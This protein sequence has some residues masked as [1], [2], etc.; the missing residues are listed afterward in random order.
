M[1]VTETHLKTRSIKITLLCPQKRDTT[2]KVCRILSVAAQ[3]YKR[4]HEA[5]ASNES[6]VCLTS[7]W[8]FW[9]NFV[10]L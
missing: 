8:H 2:I 9:S 5:K 3:H 1:L 6:A 4:M 7:I 10:K